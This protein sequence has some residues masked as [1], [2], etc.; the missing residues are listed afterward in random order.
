MSGPDAAMTG[1]EAPIAIAARWFA[2]RRS[3]GL[4][5]EESAELDAWLDADPGHRQAFRDLQVAW[6][7]VETMRD[8]PRIMAMRAEAV[9]VRP[10][11]TRA[12]VMR[13]LAASLVVAVIGLAGVWGGHTLWTGK[14]FSD[15]EYRTGI[16]QR[17]TVTLPDGSVVTL[18]TDS[19]VRTRASGDRRLVYLDRG[20]AFFKVAKNRARPFVVTAAGRTVTA[21]GTAF[22]VRID[23]GRTFK[24]T[25]VEGKVRVEA[26]APVSLVRAGTA[27]ADAPASRI[28]ATEMVAGT[29]LTAADDTRWNLAKAD[30]QRETSWTSG[31]L[32]F[33]SVPLSE[34]V[35]E[36]NRYS[37]RKILIDDAPYAD[38]PISGAF[39]AG[40]IETF[41]RGLET[42]KMAQIEASTDES[43]SLAPPQP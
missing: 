30:I 38:R 21:L 26:P 14:Q 10:G 39:R 20:Q 24:V 7:D 22:D 15:Q 31:K 43:I 29:Q 2:R 3:G 18:N 32:V 42:Y 13:A 41:A 1:Q 9:A 28:Q 16:G 6:R 37:E 11:P 19:V 25:L 23:D 33:Y 8:D 12:F 4:T 5:A 36:L 27:G 17:A 35:A 40:D 34:V